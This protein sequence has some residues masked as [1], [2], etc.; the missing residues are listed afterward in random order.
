MASGVL[1]EETKLKLLAH[2]K[3]AGKSIT[4]LEWAKL[5]GVNRAT[6]YRYMPAM[7]SEGWLKETPGPGRSILYAI[8]ANK[9]VLPVDQIPENLGKPAELK[10][11]KGELKTLLPNLLQSG[12]ERPFITA[13]TFSPQV[14]IKTVAMLYGELGR[15]KSGEIPSKEALNERRI[16][17]S[18]AQKV[19]EKF[20][21]ILNT[22]LMTPELWDPRTLA[23]YLA[24]NADSIQLG[25]WAEDVD[26]N[27]DLVISVLQALA[28]GNY[29]T[30]EGSITFDLSS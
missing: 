4:T 20:L 1:K 22:M 9:S 11:E 6:V 3:E 14:L 23:G 21:A 15:A 30:T 26:N 24:L 16:E 17:L 25:Q 7:Q 12:Y 28:Q 10:L 18:R 13:S 8:K 2:L 5:A 19:T 27:A 29:E